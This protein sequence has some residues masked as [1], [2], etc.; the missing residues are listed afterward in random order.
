MK[1]CIIGDSWGGNYA[2]IQ[3]CL[4]TALTTA[5]IDFLNVSHGGASNFGQLRLLDYQVL[6][7][8]QIDFNFILWLHTEPVRDYTEFVSLDYGNDNAAG[9]TQFPNLTNIEFYKDLEYI[10]NQNFKY[11]QQLYNEYKI[12]FLVIGGAGPVSKSIE[13]YNFAHW[14]LPNWH[15][16]FS[17]FTGI[18]P[19]N[20]YDHH[21][22]KM[23]DHGRYSKSEVLE[24]LTNIEKLHLFNSNIL[25]HEPG[26]FVDSGH[27]HTQMYLPL[28]NQIL[29]NI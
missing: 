21:V 11:A 2:P 20:C 29:E 27:P 26:I 19:V 5:G 18:M 1:F 12:P 22:V 13:Q 3:G 23:A 15:Q 10:E 7:S 6:K 28:V 8:K 25:S 4:D 24:E 14:V 17:K 9:K 16:Q